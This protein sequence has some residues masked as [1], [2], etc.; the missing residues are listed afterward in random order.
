MSETFVQRA[1][2]IVDAVLR[3]D[4]AT[5]AFAGDHRVDDR[6]P[7][8]AP[9]AVRA[10]TAM[11]R[12]ASHALAEV[13]ELELPPEDR[14]DHALLQ[15]DV[16]SR[17]FAL[18][19]SREHEW[20]PLRHNP[21]PLLH[22][23]LARPFA[24]APERLEL[25]A[26]RLAALPDALATARG[27]LRECPRIHVETAIGQ[28]GGVAAL[29]REQA[30]RLAAQAPGADIGAESA[31]AIAALE[32]FT[33]WLADQRDRSTRDPR[34]GR[35]LWEAKL[36]HT[37]DTE[38]SAA[39]LLDRARRHLDLV[40]AEIRDAAGELLG[41]AAPDD[42]T[43]RAALARL[44]A[45]HPDD[46]TVVEVALAALAEAESFVTAH[47]LVTTVDDT[48]VVQEMPEFARGVAVAYCDPVGPLETSDLPTFFA[49][50][51]APPDWP[52]E[53][54]T[55][56]YREYNNHMLR[57][58]TVHE[59][60]PGHFVQLAHARR[61]RSATAVRAMCASGTFIE[62]WA[63][64]AER[65]MSE[66]GFGGVP[67]RLQRLKS[68]L[69]T[70]INAILDQGVHCD[71]L[72]EAEAMDLM[73]RRG[74]QE[75]GEA[76][77]KWRRAQLSSTQLSTYFVGYTEMSAIA[78]ARPAAVSVRGWH[79]AMLAHG[80]PSPR[81]LRTLLGMTEP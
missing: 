78:A 30:P 12:D 9:E 34:L 52:A 22:A 35:R 64:Y 18:T 63:V 27:V 24:P 67:V 5:A 81:H 11:L 72:D 45:E 31:A 3:V 43:V 40:T 73:V 26:A 70:T 76:A 46:S 44:A 19:E 29:I 50:A 61:F 15:Q 42:D 1:E 37:L 60:V 58:L 77:G 25:L 13:D 53:R 23:L 8:W 62:G 20:N 10:Q 4:P 17:L 51:P 2:R 38:L 66:R 33:G 48:L 6:L 36:W 7:D 79:D 54:V 59:A 28:F 39:E 69:R 32:E 55:S 41:I 68:L 49:I 14:V 80:S 56:F 57:N 47:D 71:G 16:D 65:L 74:F 21:G 75:E